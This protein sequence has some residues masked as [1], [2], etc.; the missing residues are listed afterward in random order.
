M[1]YA[2]AIHRKNDCP[3]TTCWGFIDGTIRGIAR[4]VRYQRTCYNGWKRKH[5]LKYHAVVTPDGLVS[6]LFGPVEG[7]RNDAH[8]WNESGLQHYLE[9]HSFAPDGTPLQIYGDPAYGVTRHLLSPFQGASLTPEQQNFNRRM[10]A[11]RIVVEWVFKDIGQQ[12]FPFLSYVPNQRHLQQ[13]V[14]LQ[15]ITATLL[16]N[17]HICLH[18]GQITQFFNTTGGVAPPTLEEYF[19][20]PELEDFDPPNL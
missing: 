4:P 17:A 13:R 11:V 20:Q 18:G 2:Q 7:R 6:H 15:F 19:H 3:L 14:G 9:E 1:E 8:L 5:C 10:S 16:Y 12:L